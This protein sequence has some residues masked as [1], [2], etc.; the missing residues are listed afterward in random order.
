MRTVAFVSLVWCLVVRGTNGHEAGRVIV[1]TWD[2]AYLGNVKAG[3]VHTTVREIPQDGEKKLQ[4]TTELS[5]TVKKFNDTVTLRMETGSEESPNGKVTA[6][7][8]RQFLDRSQQLDMRGTVSPEGLR[9]KVDGGKR[10]DKTIPWNDEVVGLYRQS[11]FFRGRHV[12]PG[13]R[14]GYQS[15]EPIVTS[16]VTVRLHVKDYEQVQT[17][18]GKKSERLLRVEAISDKVGS[19][20]L[21][22]L[23]LWLNDAME[24]VRSQVDM[25]PLGTLTLVRTTKENAL[26]A[27]GAAKV[28]IGIGQTLMANRR[29]D[30]PYEAQSAVFRVTVKDDDDVATTF[31]Q[32]EG[33]QIKNVRG[34]SFEL[35]VRARRQPMPIAQRR[36]VESEY[37]QSCYFIKS[38]DPRIR[39][40]A[41]QAA[42]AETDPWRQALLIEQ[43]THRRMKPVSSTG[44]VA[45]ADHVART[46]EGDCTEFSFLTAAMCRSIGIPSRTALGLIYHVSN[47]RPAFNY[48][49]WV[50]VFVHGQWLPLEP[51]LG[52]SHIGAMHLKIADHSWHDVQSLTPFLPLVRI[53][54]K[55]SIEVLQV[56]SE[57]N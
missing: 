5:L 18:L 52:R 7:S 45:T 11:Q 56:G 21:P 9:V 8:M 25:A 15:F 51:T 17:P 49:M 37:L 46:L 3:F 47:Q 10:L 44:T 33:Q 19:V 28:D 2:A 53:L 1:D 12:K 6:V 29:I 42:G 35:H 22:T 34:N 36:E 57:A 50:E 41:R 43:W 14:L 24:T 27:G 40:F 38:D 30:R 54:G 4:T 16:V 48:H 39:E 26:A 31:A 32:D 20:Q 55:M 23:T 13:D